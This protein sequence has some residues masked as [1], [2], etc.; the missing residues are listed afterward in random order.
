MPANLLRG[1]SLFVE[2]EEDKDHEPDSYVST[3]KKQLHVPK[4]LWAGMPVLVSNTK[5]G[6]H[7]VTEPTM[8]YVKDFDDISVTL[9][10]VPKPGSNDD[11]DD[12]DD[13]D[14]EID[15]DKQ[16][17]RGHLEITID[18]DEFYKLQEPQVPPGGGGGGMGGG[19]GF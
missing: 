16:T 5:L 7:M 8:F 19:L 1:F 10:N 6:N 9:V 3:V 13:P 18:R 17:I 11:N 15:L 12:K 2:E 14:D 4:K